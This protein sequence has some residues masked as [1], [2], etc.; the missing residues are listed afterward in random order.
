MSKGEKY[1]S[2]TLQLLLMHETY[3]QHKTAQG[4][5]KLL[6][7]RRIEEGNE[8]GT[9][10]GTPRRPLA[11]LNMQNRDNPPLLCFLAGHNIR[12]CYG[13]S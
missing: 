10:S 2:S 7:I 9:T 13:A 8:V 3:R 6:F 4:M 1:H 11:T 5:E 12:Q